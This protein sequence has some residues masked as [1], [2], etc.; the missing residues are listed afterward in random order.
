MAF[1]LLLGVVALIGMLLLVAALSRVRVRV[2]YSRSGKCDRLAVTIRALFG[3]FRYQTVVPSIWIRGSQILYTRQTTANI[4]GEPR[5]AEEGWRVSIR[6]YKVLYKMWR[7]LK[8]QV[9]R[10]LKQVECTRFRLDFRAGTGDAPSTAMLCGLLWFAYGLALG[11]AGRTM[12]LKTKPHGA[13]E[14]EFNGKEFS[15]VWEADFRIRVVAL[16]W[17]ALKIGFLVLWQRS[18]WRKWRGLRRGVQQA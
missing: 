16:V 3:A 1:W 18:L 4:A 15:V 11:W 5:R 6:V 9:S 13:V 12:R 14:P 2:R 17:S 10:L 8:P 7:Q